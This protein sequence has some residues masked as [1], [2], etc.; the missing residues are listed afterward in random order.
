MTLPTIILDRSFGG[1]DLT[2]SQPFGGLFD[3]DVGTRTSSRLTLTDSGGAF[4]FIGTGFSYTMSGGRIVGIPTGTVTQMTQSVGSQT[5]LDWTGLS[6]SANRFFNLTAA[7][8]WSQ[9]NTFLLGKSDVFQ[10]SDGDDRVA[11]FGGHDLVDGFGGNDRLWGGAGN[12]TLRGGGG[13]DS[14]YGEAGADALYGGAGKDALQGGN[15]ADLLQGDA[16]A[17]RLEGGAGTDTLVGGGGRDTLS[18]GAGIDWLTGGA[19]Q[20]VF[21]FDRAGTVGRDMIVDFTSGVDTLRLDKNV[22]G[23]FS[24]DGALRAEDFVAGTAAMDRSDRLIYEQ[25]SGNLWYDRNGS[26][27][28][29]QVLIAELTDGTALVANDIFIF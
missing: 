2:S 15:G 3:A 29:G 24:Y 1:V 25:S 8:N 22:F 16:G 13:A 28:G 17:D 26:A 9:L 6:L 5:V 7:G 14:L 4:S 12:D 20:D 27:K 19:G 21:F 11:S 10:L 23:G 18:G